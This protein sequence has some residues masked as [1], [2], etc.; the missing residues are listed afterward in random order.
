MMFSYRRLRLIRFWSFFSTGNY[1]CFLFPINKIFYD[2]F[3]IS[4][5]AQKENKHSFSHSIGET[6]DKFI[7]RQ[8][9]KKEPNWK[10]WLRYWLYIETSWIGFY[11]FLLQWKST[12]FWLLKKSRFGFV[13][14]FPENSFYSSCVQSPIDFALQL[15][16][17]IF[18]V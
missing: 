3:I 13:H 10:S 4:L 8:L 7:L 11:W 14:N 16:K 1:F 5:L 9:Y 2:N 17:L 15:L 18:S 12:S 6:E